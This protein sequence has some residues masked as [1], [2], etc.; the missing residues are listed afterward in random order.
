M[1]TSVAVKHIAVKHQRVEQFLNRD[2]LAII[3]PE[4]RTNTTAT[5]TPPKEKLM[6][7]AQSEPSTVKKYTTSLVCY[8]CDKAFLKRSI[9]YSHYAKKHF[10]TEMLKKYGHCDRCQLCNKFFGTKNK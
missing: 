3:G 7:S 4:V 9:L 2:K 1:G 8:I 6:V 5:E 10:E